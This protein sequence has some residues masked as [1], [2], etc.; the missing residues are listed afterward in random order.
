MMLPATP[1]EGFVCDRCARGVRFVEPPFC[2][3]C[4]LPYAGEIGNEFVCT[5]CLDLDLAFEFA[6]SAV[7]ARGTVLEV[8]HRYKYRRALWFEPFLGNLLV[9]KA[10]TELVTDNWDVLVPVPLHP[11]RERDREFNQAH[12]LA[13]WLHMA[14]NIPV[15]ARCLRRVRPTRTQTQLSRAGRAD[16]MR[17]AFALRRHARVQ[18]LRCVLVDDVF[19]TGATTSECARVLKQAGARSVCVW[20]VARG[21]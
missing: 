21:L 11:P 8:I 1:A 20:T 2:Q 19:T 4:G 6:R 10:R 3:R 17:G 13:C 7:L 16:N 5:N 12:R 9:R 18:G 15:H 14:V